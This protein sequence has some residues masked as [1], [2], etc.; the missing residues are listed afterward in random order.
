MFLGSSEVRGFVEILKNSETHY[1]TMYNEEY[2]KWNCNPPSVK[3]RQGTNAHF[4]PAHRG[5]IQDMAIKLRNTICFIFLATSGLRYDVFFNMTEGEFL[6][7]EI[8]YKIHNGREIKIRR[9]LVHKHK[10]MKSQGPA[11]VYFYP[12]LWDICWKYLKVWK[13]PFM[14][15]NTGGEYSNK[16]FFVPHKRTRGNMI[17]NIDNWFPGPLKKSQKEASIEVQTKINID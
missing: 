1:D 7:A 15:T 8:L 9:V 14:S 12:E 6:E 4:D 11:E 3:S 2:E 16:P 17:N 5:A 10:T 13:K